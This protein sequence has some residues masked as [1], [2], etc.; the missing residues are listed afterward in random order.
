[1]ASIKKIFCRELLL[2]ALDLKS[3]VEVTGMRCCGMLG[4]NTRGGGLPVRKEASQQ[5]HLADA[6]Y[7]QN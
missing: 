6:D 3:L 5:D 2:V 4:S 1:M 7:Q